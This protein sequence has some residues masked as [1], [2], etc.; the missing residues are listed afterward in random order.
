MTPA[1][2]IIGAGRVG[3]ALARLLA[4]RGWHVTVVY[5][6]TPAHA[7]ALA[8][9]VN[10]QQAATPGEVLATADLTLL[11]VPDDVIGLLA[12]QLA[13]RDL[14]PRS[15]VHTS[16]ALGAEA[17]APLAARG[18]HTGSLHPAFPFAGGVPDLSGVAFAVEAGDDGLRA[19]LLALVAALGGLPLI[20]PPGGKAQ[21]HAALVMASNYAV[22]LYGIAERLLTD[23]GVAA[24]SADTVLNGLLAGTL[25]NLREHGAAGAL[26]GPL[27]RADVGTLRLHLRALRAADPAVA[28]LYVSLARQTYPLLEARGVAVAAIERLMEEEQAHAP[29]CA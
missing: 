18:L 1:L 16:G 23:L 8:D 12:E 27:V 10:A 24:A 20:I 21:Y 26:T 9:A 22:T 19:D 25:A 11:A 6:R 29:D 15:V 14:P 4:A 17:L 5:S 7:A 2:G 13:E 3:S 28:D